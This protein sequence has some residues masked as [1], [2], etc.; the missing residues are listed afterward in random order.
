[1]IVITVNHPKTAT[2]PK[3]K[4]TPMKFF[5]FTERTNPST[6]KIVTSPKIITNGKVNAPFRDH[7]IAVLIVENKYVMVNYTPTT[8]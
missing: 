8:F 2:V 4:S 6:D 3:E 1:M 5:S 7:S